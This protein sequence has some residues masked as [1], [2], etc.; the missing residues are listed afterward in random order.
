VQHPLSIPSE[1]TRGPT[2]RRR[3]RQTAAGWSL[4]LAAVLFGGVVAADLPQSLAHRGV[5]PQALQQ[6]VH[7]Q[8]QALSHQNAGAAFAL[9]DADLRTQF[10]TAEAFLETVREEYPMLMHPASLLFLKPSTD[11]SVA[12]QKVRLTDEEG[13]SWSLT[14]VLNRQQDN[15]W[16]ISGCIVTPEGRQVLT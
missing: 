10:G 13:A 3:A 7:Q 9:A 6:V 12:M 4:V 14:Y 16:K 5:A 8:L 1:V 11:G 15:Q 2:R